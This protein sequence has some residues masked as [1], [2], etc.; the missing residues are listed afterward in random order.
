MQCSAV[1]C[2]AVLCSA[3]LCSAVQYS[4]VLCSAVKYGPTMW[5][6]AGLQCSALLLTDCLVHCSA[7][8]IFAVYVGRVI[9]CNAA[10]YA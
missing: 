5:P 7:V 3:V 2:S 9:T 6:I 10:V 8:L 4:A 1:L